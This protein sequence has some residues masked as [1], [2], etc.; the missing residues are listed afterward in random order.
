MRRRH[1]TVTLTCRVRNILADSVDDLEQ[2]ARAVLG[3]DV[4]GG[5]QV[6]GKRTLLTS[7]LPPYWSV[8][9]LTRGLKNL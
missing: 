3:H 5:E 9:L 8:R 4:N 6:C 1:K 2:D 7:R